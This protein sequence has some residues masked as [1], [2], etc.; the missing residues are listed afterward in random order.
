[1]AYFLYAFKSASAFIVS[2]H[3]DKSVAFTHFSHSGRYNIYR[4]PVSI[5]HDIYAISKRL[6]YCLEMFPYIIDP[7]LIMDLPIL[8]NLIFLPKAILNNKGFGVP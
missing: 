8:R 7:V 1:M 3:V 4:P 6:F 5:P 2:V